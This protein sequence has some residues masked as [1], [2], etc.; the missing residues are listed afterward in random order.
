M[1]KDGHQV[2]LKIFQGAD[3]QRLLTYRR[4]HFICAVF[5]ALLGMFSTTAHA[6]F[7]QCPPIGLSPGCSIL[8]TINPSGRLTFQVDSSVPP[9]D[10]VEDVLVGVTNKSGATIYGIQL[11]G[12]DIFGFDGDGANNGSYA[13]PGTSFTI[14]DANNGTVN[15]PNGLDDGN[16]LWFSLEGNPANVKLSRTVTIDPGHGGTACAKGLTGATGPIYKDTEHAL[17]LAIGLGLKARFES[18]GDKVTMTRTSAVCPTPGERAETANNANTNVFVS[19]HF[20]G[21][22]A[23]AH[24][25]QVWYPPA[26]TS[27]QQLATF[28]VADTAASLGLSNNGILRSGIDPP[29]SGGKSIGVLRDTDMSAIL[30]EVAYL[31]N[32]GK[33]GGDEKVMHDPAAI[34][35]AGSGLFSGIGKFFDQ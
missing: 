35:K 24:G 6:L 22:G 18:N 13:G 19:I 26:K 16:S 17:A 29:W 5:V 20:N 7:T 31:S 14:V 8:I 28:V 11:T 23:S 10:G 33:G 34:G 15:F 27:S 12:N 4:P 30:V 9:Y 32:D 3:M 2:K 25:S 21:A 1:C